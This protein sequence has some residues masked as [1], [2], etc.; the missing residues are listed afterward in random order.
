MGF[1][2]TQMTNKHIFKPSEADKD[3]CEHCGANFRDT[4]KHINSKSDP[5]HPLFAGILEAY[6]MKTPKTE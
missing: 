4:D 1:N 3:T 5:L 6:G 2:V